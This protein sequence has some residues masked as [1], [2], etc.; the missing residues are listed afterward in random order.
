MDPNKDCTL[1]YVLW[2]R[3]VIVFL[4]NVLSIRSNMVCPVTL[5]SWF[6][7]QKKS[8]SFKNLLVIRWDWSTGE[9]IKPLFTK[10]NKIYCKYL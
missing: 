1:L 2:C 6:L 3:F 5:N 8:P 10:I 9:L 7:L 4:F